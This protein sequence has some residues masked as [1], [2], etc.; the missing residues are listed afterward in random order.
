MVRVLM[1]RFSW[2]YL[3]PVTE[4]IIS[5]EPQEFNL[6]KDPGIWGLLKIRLFPD[7]TETN[8]DKIHS[9]FAFMKNC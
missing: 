5:K 8:K 6:T 7:S 4:E 1:T 2:H 9:Y 3:I